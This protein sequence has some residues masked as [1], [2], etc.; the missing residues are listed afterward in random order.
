MLS[1]RVCRLA[2]GISDILRWA[3]C[4][5]HRVSAHLRGHWVAGQARRL[6]RLRGLRP[7][8]YSKM[9]LCSCRT[10]ERSSS[11]VWLVNLLL[12]SRLAFANHSVWPPRC[13][14]ALPHPFGQDSY[15]VVGSAQ[16]DGTGRRQA[17]DL[18]DAVC[19]Q[20]TP[21]RVLW[22][23]SLVAGHRSSWCHPCASAHASKCV[24]VL[25]QPAGAGLKGRCLPGAY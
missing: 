24:L 7:A 25:L 2:N 18:Q 11:C 4:L 19:F 1:C 3:A 12:G 9:C 16:Q 8:S 14:E 23:L 5:E 17:L 20:L 15:E 13:Q 22:L 10:Q 6:L 21:C